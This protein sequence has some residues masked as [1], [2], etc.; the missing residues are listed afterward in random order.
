MLAVVHTLQS[1]LLAAIGAGMFLSQQWQCRRQFAR[2]RHRQ[3]ALQFL[4]PFRET[5]IR[6]PPSIVNEPGWA[7]LHSPTMR[8]KAASTS[9]AVQ[10]TSKA[11]KAAPASDPDALWMIVGLGNPGSQYERTRHNVSCTL[12]NCTS[13]FCQPMCSQ[14]TFPSCACVLACS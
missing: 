10:Q 14:R 3:G 1:K 6:L 5:G 2:C 11:P 9:V 4:A 13:G 7:F 12:G 8:L